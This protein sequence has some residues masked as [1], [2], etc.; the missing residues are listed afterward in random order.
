VGERDSGGHGRPWLQQA[1]EG[2]LNDVPI[3]SARLRS[4]TVSH[5]TNELPTALDPRCHRDLPGASEGSRTSGPRTRAEEQAAGRQEKD[6]V[7]QAGG[8]VQAGGQ[9]TRQLA[10]DPRHSSLNTHEH[11]SLMNPFDPKDKT[12]TS[13]YRLSQRRVLRV[14]GGEGQ[15]LGWLQRIAVY[16]LLYR[17]RSVSATRL[18]PTLAGVI[19]ETRPSKQRTPAEMKSIRSRRSPSCRS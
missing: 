1:R 18:V 2:E 9:A 14:P 16:G 6:E 13:A 5:R 15:P 17:I 12:G 7:I 3:S 10:T 4:L 11:E 19:R 8:A